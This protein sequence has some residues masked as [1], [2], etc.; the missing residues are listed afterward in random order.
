MLQWVV[1]C[2]AVTIEALAVIGI[3][4]VRVWAEESTHHGVIYAAVHVN[5]VELLE[6]LMSGESTFCKNRTRL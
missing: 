1:Q 5:Q 6:V 3:L 4:D 2:V